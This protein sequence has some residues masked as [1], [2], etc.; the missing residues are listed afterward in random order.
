M[1]TI[2]DEVTLKM[3]EKVMLPESVLNPETGKYQKTGKKVEN[4]TYTFVDDQFNKLVF[5]SSNNEMR[6]LE[7]QK[8]NLYLS[9]VHDD[10]NGVNKVKFNGFI[11]RN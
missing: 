7:G 2:F 4:T 5:L 8:G 11:E 3:C 6:K 9:I 1:E 10:F